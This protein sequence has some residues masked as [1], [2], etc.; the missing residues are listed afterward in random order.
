MNLLSGGSV[1]SGLGVVAGVVGT[2]MQER[3]VEDKVVKLGS[4]TFGNPIFEKVTKLAI[5]TNYKCPGMLC[6]ALPPRREVPKLD[7]QS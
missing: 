2:S 1:G 3:K 7:F 4:D 5:L 6:P